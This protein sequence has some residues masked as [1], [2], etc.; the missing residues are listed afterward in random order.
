MFRLTILLFL[1][2]PLTVAAQV[3]NI[4]DAVLRAAIENDLGKAAGNTITAG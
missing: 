4:S 2:L 3:V 1:T